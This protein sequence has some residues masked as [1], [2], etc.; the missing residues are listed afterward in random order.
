MRGVTPRRA[1]VSRSITSDVC[2]PLVL[3]VGVDVGELGQLATAPRGSSAP[4]S[5]S[6]S[7]SSACS[8]NWY[9]ALALPAADADVLHRAEEEVRAGL[10]REL[11]RAAA[12]SPG[13]RGSSRSASGFSATNIEPGC[14][15]PPPVKPTTF[16]TA[17]S[18]A[19]DRDEVGELLAH[20]LERDALVGL[21]EADEA[22]GVL[23]RE[24]ALG[25]D[26]VEVDVEADRREQDEHHERAVAQR[27]GEACARS[28]ASTRVEGALAPR[29]EAAGL[30]LRRRPQQPRAH[31]RRRGERDHQRD[32]GSP[33]DS[34]TANSRN[35]RPTMPPI[36][37]I[38]MN[39]ATSD[40]LIDSTVKPTSRAPCSAASHRRHAALDVAR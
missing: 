24:E 4:T 8:V 32:A 36:S 34:V 3:L 39:T 26:H 16:S 23:L 25:H 28:R 31:H 12:R 7:R 10:L 11:A 18:R 1:A 29:C 35:S 5:R 17:G 15:A 21:D 13:R 2:R 20:R 14:A 9:C 40:T 38:G 30:A 37:R 19:H 6:S 22:P 27:P 33:T